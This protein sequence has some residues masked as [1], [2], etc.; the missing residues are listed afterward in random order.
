M[1]QLV[2][3]ETRVIQCTGLFQNSLFCKTPKLL[4]GMKD[5]KAAEG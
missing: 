4:V 2:D 5:T 3:F 1:Y